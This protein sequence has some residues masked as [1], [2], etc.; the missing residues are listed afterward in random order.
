MFGGTRFFNVL[1]VQVGLEQLPV[2]ISF[3]PLQVEEVQEQR[4]VALDVLLLE[5]VVLQK[6]LCF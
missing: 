3:L 5:V 4:L 6:F 2:E 1:H